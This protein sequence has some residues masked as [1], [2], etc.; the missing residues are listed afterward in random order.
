MNFTGSRHLGEIKTSTIDE[1][2][3]PSRD[4]P[5]FLKCLTLTLNKGKKLNFL[6]ENLVLN[7]L[8]KSFKKHPFILFITFNC[9]PC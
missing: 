6:I 5:I 4:P 1:N 8:F 2:K 3:W 9:Q 7:F